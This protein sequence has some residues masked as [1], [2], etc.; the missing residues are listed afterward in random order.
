MSEH[1]SCCAGLASAKAEIQRLQNN[2]A[3]Q[4]KIIVKLQ[5]RLTRSGIDAR[6][7]SGE[8]HA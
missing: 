5:E 4:A 2:I 7:D 8:K 6:P 3:E 1:E